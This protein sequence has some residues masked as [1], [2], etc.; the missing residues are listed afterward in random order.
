MILKI[1]S[2][3]EQWSDNLFR[4]VVIDHITHEIFCHVF[5]K[6]AKE[7]DQRAND[8]IYAYN[9]SEVTS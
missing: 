9:T 5:G 8:L 7:C 3:I 1:D 4:M 2:G 6:T